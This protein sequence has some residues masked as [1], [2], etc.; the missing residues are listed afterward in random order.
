VHGC[1]P[2]LAIAVSPTVGKL[3]GSEGDGVSGGGHWASRAQD[4][5]A[6]EWEER[7][8]APRV[9]R[10]FLPSVTQGMGQLVPGSAVAVVGIDPWALDWSASPLDVARM[11]SRPLAKGGLL[12]LFTLT[13]PDPMPT[14][15]A[16]PYDT[17]MGT[18]MAT[19]ARSVG[20]WRELVPGALG[21]PGL[22]DGGG[23]GNL[24]GSGLAVRV[25]FV[26]IRAAAGAPPRVASDFFAS[27]PNRPDV[28]PSH[29]R[30]GP[31]GRRLRAFFS[32]A[33]GSS[34]SGGEQLMALLEEPSEVSPD[35][36]GLIAGPDSAS[37]S[38]SLPV[39][40]SSQFGAKVL[41]RSVRRERGAAAG[42]R[43]SSASDSGVRVV[44]VALE[45]A[46]GDTVWSFDPA[47]SAAWLREFHE[48]PQLVGCAR[49]E[50]RCPPPQTAC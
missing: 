21:T 22:C 45:E 23:E 16:A 17:D 7:C 24:L 28:P 12:L 40:G 42:W 1:R 48:E 27:L 2:L 10:M 36:R 37:S 38:G 8:G 4:L 49:C 18:A 32:P 39:D 33:S 20:A 6:R 5:G 19:V 25:A 35:G 26:A 14:P 13:P 3:R 44:A 31:I 30:G 34:A 41:P 9:L 50:Q 43:R 29:S 47:A 46:G 15:G 11:L